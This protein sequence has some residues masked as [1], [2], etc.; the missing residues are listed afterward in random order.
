MGVCVLNKNGERLKIKK[1]IYIYKNQI[2]GLKAG[3]EKF[4][5]RIHSLEFN[6]YRVYYLNKFNL[7]D[8]KSGFHIGLNFWQNQQFLLLQNE[9]WIQKEENIRYVIN[10]LFLIGGLALGYL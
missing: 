4:Y 9:H 1:Y 10:I 6:F 8:G 2:H 3:N 5:K 7:N